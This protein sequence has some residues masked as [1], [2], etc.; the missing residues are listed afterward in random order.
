M[1]GA[2]SEGPLAVGDRPAH[3]TTADSAAAALVEISGGRRRAARRYRD[4]TRGQPRADSTAAQSTGG[5]GGEI[6]TIAVTAYAS[7]ADRD[8]APAAGYQ[9]HIATPFEAEVLVHLIASLGRSAHS[10]S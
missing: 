3:V 1:I 10:P 8:A 9:A 6:P 7:I 4:A 5:R 2:R